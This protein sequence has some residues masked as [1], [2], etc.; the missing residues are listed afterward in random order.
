LGKLIKFNIY[1][2]TSVTQEKKVGLEPY[3]ERFCKL[4]IKAKFNYLSVVSVHAPTEE[5][6]DEEKEKFYEVLQIVRNKIP[7]HDIR[8]LVL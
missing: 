7:K 8:G 4:R 3:N 5:K 6:A 1:P 2:I